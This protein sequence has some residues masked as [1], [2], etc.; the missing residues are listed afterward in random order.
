MKPIHIL[1]ASLLFALAPSNVAAAPETLREFDSPEQRQQYHQLLQ[2]LRCLVCQNESLASSGAGLADDLRNEVYRLY[3]IEDRSREETIGFLTD[4]YGDFVL[5]RP[6]MRPDTWLLWFGP[7]LML[8]LG[9]AVLITVI[10]RRRR[11]A[12]VELEPEERE[13]AERL[14]RGEGD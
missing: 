1:L 7:L 11:A 10:R 3:V 13:R 8:A 14:L 9:A 12:P 4:R 6:P 2:E 5:Y